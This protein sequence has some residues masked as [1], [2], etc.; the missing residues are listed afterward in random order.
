MIKTIKRFFI[1]IFV[2]FLIVLAF[3]VGDHYGT[4]II[5]KLGFRSRSH[6]QESLPD[7][8]PHTSDQVIDKEILEPFDKDGNGS[9][10][11]KQQR[12]PYTLKVDFSPVV[13]QEALREKKLIIM[14]QNATASETAE[15]NGLFKLPFF[16][17]T[18]AII[19][20]GEGTYHVDLSSL[21][22][23]DFLIDNDKKSITISIP[24]PELSVKLLPKKTEF[25]DSSNGLLRFGEMQIPPEMMTELEADGIE[26][27]TKSLESDTNIHEIVEK[28]TKLSVKEIY[29]PLVKAQ[30]DAAV[31]NADDEYAIAPYYTINVEIKD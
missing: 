19:F 9:V 18:K 28:F 12:V 21:S 7:T 4:S 22:D 6:T 15:K 8:G 13:F 26:Q 17:Q 25:F 16:K 14:T 30:V 2:L 1:L 23:S 10:E 29:E 20:H 5:S 24:Q 31:K 3:F 27:I 11:Y